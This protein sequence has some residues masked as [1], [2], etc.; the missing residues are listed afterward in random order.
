MKWLIGLLVVLAALAG[1]AWYALL[2]A[3]GPAQTDS[4]FDLAAY[5]ALV[6]D[7]A[8][9]TLPTEV[10]VEFVGSSEAPGFAAEAGAFGGDRTF[11]YTSFEIVSPSG[12]TIVDGAVD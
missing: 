3:D 2:D 10:R 7:D 6:A 4:P 1:L 11:S 12:N 5:R 9:E 8:P